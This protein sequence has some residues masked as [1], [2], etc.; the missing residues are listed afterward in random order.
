MIILT[1]GVSTL[2]WQPQ[3]SGL[4]FSAYVD[5]L[6]IFFYSKAAESGQPVTLTFSPRGWFVVR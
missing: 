6:S 2:K 5:L 4:L 3:Q 1:E